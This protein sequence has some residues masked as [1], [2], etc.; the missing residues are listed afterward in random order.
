MKFPLEKY[1][2]LGVDLLKEGYTLK[3]LVHGNSMFP[4]LINKRFVKVQS[5]KYQ[6]L[7]KGDIIVFWMQDKL[8]AHRIIGYHKSK[9][10]I[11]TRGDFCL[12][13][14]PPVKRK[15]VIGKIIAVY[16][17]GQ[18]FSVNNG[19]MICINYLI[20]KVHAFLPIFMRVLNKFRIIKNPS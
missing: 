18:A 2:K 12:R 19:L 15:E 14:D 17:N 10:S 16:I 11:I 6:K 13:K 5:V 20:S 7:R 4:Y 3:L 8:I 9:D 1:K